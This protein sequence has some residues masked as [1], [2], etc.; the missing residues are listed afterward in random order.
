MS[1]IPLRRSG[2]FV[3][4]AGAFAPSEKEPPRA[5]RSLAKIIDN[6]LCHRCGSCVGICPTGVLG[7]DSSDYP[8]VKNLSACTDCDLCVKVCPG[9]EFNA[10]EAAKAL[11]GKAPQPDDLY[12]HFLSS[13]LAYNPDE[14]KRWDGTS[15][16]LVSTLLAHM[17]QSGEID[18]A[19]VVRA[20]PQQ[21]WKGE[22]FIA[23]TPEE[24]WSAAKSKYVIVPTN[25]L[26]QV[27]IQNP[28]RYA[29][30]GLPCTIHGY[31][32]AA[33]LNRKLKER[34]VFTIG[35]L[36]HAAVDHE[37][38]ATVWDSVDTGGKQANRFYYR[39][40]KHA[41]NAV[42]VL[43]DGT[44]QNALFPYSKR[45]EAS[46]IELMNI[47]YRLY[48]PPRCFTCYDSMAEYADLSVGD[49]WMVPPTD[50]IDFKKGYS[51]SLCRTPAAERF[52][53]AAEQAGVLN[54][55]PLDPDHARTSN[56][57]MGREKRHRAFRLLNS[58]LRQ[59]LPIPQYGFDAPPPA[60]SARIA[61]EINLLTHLFCFYPRFR[62]P[63]LRFLL[64]RAGF[65][66]FWLN[67]K[68]RRFRFFIR[69]SLFR[70]R[71][72]RSHETTTG[73]I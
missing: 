8:A 33:N 72:R 53:R 23:R 15:G 10:P 55:I 38:P 66:L 29:L 41:G 52:L 56:L 21:L 57:H 61:T 30:V 54:L 28:G 31:L 47:L 19:L 25:S 71:Q 36:C 32:K 34:V 40:G 49:P 60:G 37:A 67:D 65:V 9:D 70:R 44:V 42:V 7:L 14:P 64:S 24:I 43:E 4:P 11:F 3:A 13:Y 27:I 51:Y 59:G 18:G 26:L 1:F 20:H 6:D 39:Y 16:G 46:A 63:L 68:Q 62:R 35:L 73:D 5:L 12:G 17:L 2:P 22:P 69:K 48:T 58:R 45:Y 50:D